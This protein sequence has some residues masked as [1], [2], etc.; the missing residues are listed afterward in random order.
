M[1]KMDG[2]SGMGNDLHHGVKNPP[3]CVDQINQ[4]CEILFNVPVAVQ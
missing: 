4:H 2:Q 1:A 3:I